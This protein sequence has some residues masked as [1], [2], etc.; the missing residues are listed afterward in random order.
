MDDSCNGL[1]L[2]GA[3]CSAALPNCSGWGGNGQALTQAG[4]PPP[5][6]Q[7]TAPNIAI[8]RLV[9]DGQGVSDAKLTDGKR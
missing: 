4:V 1:R 6:L 7:K 3:L 8:R 5:G 9:G 2:P